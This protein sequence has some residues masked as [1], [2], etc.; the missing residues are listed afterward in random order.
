MFDDLAAYYHENVAAAFIEYRET[1]RDGVAGRSRDLRGAID[2]ATALFHLREHLPTSAALTRAEV[3]RRCSDYALLSDVVN[4]AKHKRLT[5]ATPHGSPLVADA[6]SL[7]EKLLMVEY[8]DDAGIYR[9]AQKSVVAVLSDGSERNLLEVLTNVINFWEAHLQS[10]GTLTNARRFNFEP[11]V[12]YRTRAECDQIR[13]D[14]EIVQGQRFKQTMQL[15]RFDN[16][17]NTASPVDLT[18]SELKFSIYKP[19]YDFEVSLT[20]EASGKE[21]ST[22]VTL[23]EEES[24]VL[25]DLATDEARQSY[26]T[27]LPSTQAALR[28]LAEQAG[29]P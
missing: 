26:A 15:L 24:A 13:L 7:V 3:E 1:S 27:S 29:I 16:A 20:Q 2:A 9:C 19:R 11:Q 6:T 14:F 5:G 23:S 28:K 10:I 25:S 22:S 12:R 17:T 4:A 8:S 21:Y 18:G